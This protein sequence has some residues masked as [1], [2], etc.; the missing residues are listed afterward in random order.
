MLDASPRMLSQGDWSFVDVFDAVVHRGF[1]LTSMKSMVSSVF[2]LCERQ[3]LSFGKHVSPMET[4][5]HIINRLVSWIGFLFSPSMRFASI[6]SLVSFLLT[7]ILI[8]IPGLLVFYTTVPIIW[9]LFPGYPVES[10]VSGDATWPFIL[11]IGFLWSASFLMLGFFNL[12]LCRYQLNKT[13]RITICALAQYALILLVCTLSF[14]NMYRSKTNADFYDY[15]VHHKDVAF[16]KVLIKKGLV[17]NPKTKGPKT[18][19]PLHI[20]VAYGDSSFVKPL[21][22]HGADIKLRNRD[23]ATVLY[24]A[25]VRKD[26]NML[27]FLLKNGAIPPSN[28]VRREKYISYLK[29]NPSP[30]A[31][32]VLSLFLKTS[33]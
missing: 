20:A 29:K 8:G 11:S 3:P 15:A 4:I 13:I 25:L 33:K 23:N 22:K 21:L 1:A 19:Y 2:C 6:A 5:Q 18:I 26:L 28:K 10:V 31:K 12:L 27:A 32:A 7:F 17:L 24:P 14:A 9:L 16:L 30:K